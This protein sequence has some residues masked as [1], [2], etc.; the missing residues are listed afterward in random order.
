M[1][2]KKWEQNPPKAVIL[3]GGKGT[4][5][6]PYTTVLPK[7]LM[8]IGGQPILEILISRLSHSG[9]RDLIISVGHL[10]EL[11]KTFFG[12]G[13]KWNVNI[14]Y[15]I[16]DK[17]LG[18]MGP[19]SLMKN[20]GTH[21]FV[22]NGDVLTDLDFCSFYQSHIDSGSIMTVATCRRNVPIDFGVLD[23]D[24]KSNKIVSFQEKPTL[25]YHVSMGIYV[26]AEKCLQYIPQ[27]T[28]FGFDDLI[29]SLIHSGGKV[30]SYLHEGQWL[31]IGRESDYLLANEMIDQSLE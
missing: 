26:L 25:S 13:N 14:E 31:D 20:L 23:F 11:I 18:T 19:L 27:N 24:P 17:P 28:Y 10:A 6:R 3:A 8:P 16:E 22:M 9:I 5:L 2:D 7:P 30:S 29:L 1:N 21:F 12:H 15:V 4:R